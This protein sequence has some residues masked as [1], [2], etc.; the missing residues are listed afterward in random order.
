MLNEKGRTRLFF[1]TIAS[2]KSKSNEPD[3][4]TLTIS[5][6]RKPISVQTKGENSSIYFPIKQNSRINE[7]YVRGEQALGNSLVTAITGAET[8]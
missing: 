7:L 3:R 5:L 8:L 2:K 4:Q 1:K 6:S